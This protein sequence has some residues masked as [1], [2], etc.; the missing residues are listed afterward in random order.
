LSKISIFREIHP[1]A[2]QNLTFITKPNIHIHQLIPHIIIFSTL[3]V[4]F[5][6]MKVTTALLIAVGL[7]VASVSALPTKANVAS[8]LEHKQERRWFYV[9]AYITTKADEPP[10]DSSEHQKE[11]RYFYVSPA[12][13]TKADEPPPDDSP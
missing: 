11:R 10:P 2:F 4:L 7:L 1:S 13:K 9:G 3:I 12:G 8:A 6:I 5:F